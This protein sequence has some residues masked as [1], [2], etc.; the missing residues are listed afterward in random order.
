MC[1]MYF[2]P[3]PE[4]PL[5]IR[6]VKIMEINQSKCCDVMSLLVA[7]SDTLNAKIKKLIAI[8]ICS[9]KKSSMYFPNALTWQ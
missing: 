4:S 5:P 2:L 9:N 8:A 3:S 7:L 6:G 1:I